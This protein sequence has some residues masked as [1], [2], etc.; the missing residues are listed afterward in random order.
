MAVKNRKR[1]RNYFLITI[2]LSVAACASRPG[3]I[4]ESAAP[5]FTPS[6]YQALPGWY[7]DEWA[8]FAQAFE[9]SCARLQKRDASAPFN[10]DPRFGNYKDWQ[11][12]CDAFT[13]INKDEPTST[14][15]FLEHYFTPY[16]VSA[17]GNANG[18]FTGYYEASLK[19]SRTKSAQYNVPLHARPDDLV[20]VNL[21]EFREELKG[22]RIAGRVIEGNLKPYE[23]RE[24]ILAG[25]MKDEKVLVWVDDPVEAFFVQVQGSGVVE[26]D[27]GSR[28]R[29]GYAGQNGHIY[30]AIGR[31]LV[32]RGALPKDDVSMQ[33]IRSWLAAHPADAAALMNTNKSYVFFREVDG[34]GPVGGEGVALSPLRSLA[35][36]HGKYPYGFPVWL[37][38]ET[39]PMK[40]LMMAQDT[41]G[42]IKGAVRGDVFWGYGDEAE[43]QA[44]MM[45]SPGRYWIL[46]PKSITP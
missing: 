29:I 35:I 18:L 40:R 44:G 12:P 25:P 19:G 21:G 24:E 23:T 20:M 9:R 4:D 27:D 16:A 5:V 3:A 36:D 10:S 1:M 30:Y 15:V 17:G 37:V 13:K 31:E 38:T 41:G 43:A 46:L 32:K 14:R 33:S 11:A 28:M 8:G 22:Q 34:D 26:L 6:S 2:L 42:A 7:E 45:K 39:P